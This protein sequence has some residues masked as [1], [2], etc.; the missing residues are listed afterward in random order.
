[1]WNPVRDHFMGDDQ[2]RVPIPLDGFY[3][4]THTNDKGNIAIS[5][6]HITVIFLN[7]DT[8]KKSYKSFP[9]GLFQTLV[10]GEDPETIHCLMRLFIIYR[11]N[12]NVWVLFYSILLIFMQMVVL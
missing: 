5:P 9:I 7:L 1:M 12:M 3:D 11:M 2:N 4:K 6:F 10:K 8:R